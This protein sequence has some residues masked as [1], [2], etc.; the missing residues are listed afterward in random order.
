MIESNPSAKAE[1]SKANPAGEA[2]EVADFTLLSKKLLA[3]DTH[4]LV[5]KA[6]LVARARKPGQFV[7]FLIH[8]RGERIPI[9]LKGGDAE[10]ATAT[11]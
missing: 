8:E 5:F 1:V 11:V 10:A 7:I 6:P 2:S 4:E 9:S 3:P